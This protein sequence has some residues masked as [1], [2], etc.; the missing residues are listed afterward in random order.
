M[1]PVLVT[2]EIIFHEGEAQGFTKGSPE[3]SFVDFGGKDGNGTSARVEFFG[4][5]DKVENQ[6]SGCE[7]GAKNKDESMLPKALEEIFVRQ[8]EERKDGDQDKGGQAISDIGMKPDTK[9]QSG[10]KESAKTFGAETLE[11]EI[12][13]KR[14]EER[15]HDGPEADSGKVDGPE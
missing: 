7:E 2:P 3:I 1:A 6:R 15:H 10:N 9:D 8:N 14:E 13:S 5:R 11:E 12:K 4:M